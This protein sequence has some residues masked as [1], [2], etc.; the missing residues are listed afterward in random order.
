MWK[1]VADEACV[2]FQVVQAVIDEVGADRVGL[3]L[4][5]FVGAH[6]IHDEHTYALNVYLL[7][8]LNKL[9]IA[10]VHFVEPRD[11]GSL[12]DIF[13]LHL[14]ELVPYKLACNSRK[15]RTQL[16]YDHVPEIVA[17]ATPLA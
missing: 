6:K 11:G 17:K 4:A 5:P 3:R 2:L 16:C 1:L 15:L 8:E 14:T 7:E 9:D 12:A 13:S 10:Y